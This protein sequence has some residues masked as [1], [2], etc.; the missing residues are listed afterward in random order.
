[1]I[2]LS[3]SIKLSAPKAVSQHAL[4]RD[5]RGE[6]EGCL[7]QHPRDGQQLQPDTH[8]HRP[9]TRGRLD[10]CLPLPVVGTEVDLV[11]GYG[12]Q[13]LRRAE[14]V[15]DLGARDAVENLATLGAI[16]DEAA[17]LQ[18]GQVS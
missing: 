12:Q 15:H 8:A 9:G 10:H 13:R 16:D 1:M 6:G 4:R 5:T 7:D 2:P 14:D 3:S 18:A 17:V 11:P